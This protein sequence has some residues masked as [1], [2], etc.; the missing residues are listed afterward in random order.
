MSSRMQLICLDEQSF[1]Q[2]REKK[3]VYVDKTRIM[4]DV[5]RDGKYFFISRPRRFGKSLLCSTLAALFSGKRDL[6][7]G[8][9]IEQSDWEWQS[10]P[11]IHLNMGEVASPTHSAEK[12]EA[13]LMLLL[14]G[15]ARQYAV[16]VIQTTVLEL[17]FGQLIKK[18]FEKTGQRVVVI[19]DEYDKPLLDVIHEKD[20]YPRIHDVLRGFYS[21]LKNN[22][23]FLRFVLLTGVFKFA[24][25]SVFSGLNNI[26]D[27]TFDPKAAELLG[28]TEQELQDYFAEHLASL[29]SGY[30]KTMPEML[31]ILREKYNGYSFGINDMVG[32]IVGSVYN[33]FALNYVL[34]EQQLLE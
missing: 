8:L 23:E 32:N 33:P 13:G 26:K 19:I 2:I 29:A 24:K 21:Q 12:V 27:V 31:E 1:S 4:Y 17:Y 16:E 9:W 34:N 30:K 7:K 14:Q 28:Y 3:G 6:F 25:T 10:Y 22:S 11:V 20:Q 18:L 15:V 5:F